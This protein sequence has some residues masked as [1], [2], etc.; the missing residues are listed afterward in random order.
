MISWYRRRKIWL[1]QN[2]LDLQQFKLQGDY[3][4]FDIILVYI[5]LYDPV[6]HCCSELRWYSQVYLFQRAVLALF[7]RGEVS[8]NTASTSEAVKSQK[9]HG[10][11]QY[12]CN[13]ASVVLSGSPLS[14]SLS[15][16]C[17]FLSCGRTSKARGA[18]SRY[19]AGSQQEQGPVVCEEGTPKLY[20]YEYE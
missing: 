11:L 3:Y 8:G 16:L 14:L 13:G 19:T 15:L 4:E 9:T 2:S 5:I 12:C 1:F 20:E 17:L 7:H 18:G 10:V 6:F